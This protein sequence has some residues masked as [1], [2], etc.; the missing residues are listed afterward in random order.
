MASTSFVPSPFIIII[1]SIFPYLFFLTYYISYYLSIR[2]SVIILVFSFPFLFSSWLLLFLSPFL[3]LS[4]FCWFLGN[5]YRPPLAVFF[6]FFFFFFAPFSDGGFPLYK[7]GSLTLGPATRYTLKLNC[8]YIACAYIPS[9]NTHIAYT[10]YFA[11]T[12]E[13]WRKESNLVLL[14]HSLLTFLGP[15]C[16]QLHP[17]QGYLSPSWRRL[18]RFWDGSLRARRFLKRSKTLLVRCAVPQLALQKVFP[19]SAKAIMLAF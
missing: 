12:T 9:K 7:K 11:L 13:G 6:L 1:F 3:S 17:L 8:I 14:L 19:H 2:F 5:T 4:T 16:P 10:Y 15:K 18:Q